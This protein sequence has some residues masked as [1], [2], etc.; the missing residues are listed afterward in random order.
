MK[1]N[2]LIIASA[3]ILTL[4]VF[5]IV[6][7]KQ[8]NEYNINLAVLKSKNKF[9]QKQSEAF[10]QTVQIV[11][12]QN[13][14]LQSKITE[15][16]ALILKERQKRYSDNA[17]Y[18]DSIKSLSKL[19]NNEQMSLFL[20]NSY[21]VKTFGDSSHF[22]TPIEPVKRANVIAMENKSNKSLVQSL[23]RENS[24]LSDNIG[25]LKETVKNDSIIKGSMEGQLSISYQVEDNLNEQVKA[26]HKL[27]KVEKRKRV[28]SQIICVAELVV[29]GWLVVK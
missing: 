2:I 17:K 26:E 25:R 4:I 19:S 24:E 29:I 9:L 11:T 18:Q 23:T 20:G 6:L 22:I 15:S 16:E 1:K 3:I 28:V 8:K 21:P 27:Y 5:W 13:K 14:A 7:N 12:A 10:Q